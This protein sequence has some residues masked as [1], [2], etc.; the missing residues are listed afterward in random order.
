ME[1]SIE[2]PNPLVSDVLLAQNGDM[3]AYER[4]IKHCQNLV[5]SI[6]LSIV[7]DI[8][9]SEEVAQ[10]VF[11]SVW[12]NLNQLKSP[13]S[14]LPWV[15]Q[16]TRYTAF[17]FLRDNKVSSKVGSIHA[18]L[19]LEQLTGPE[20]QNEEQLYIDNQQLVLRHFIDELAQEEREIVLLYYR[21][22]QSSKQ[23]ARLLNLTEAN[24]R[25]KLSRVR[26]SLKSSLLKNASA[27]I[28][29]TAPAL[30]FSALIT[31]VLVPSSPVA[32]AAIASTIGTSS[33]ASTGF[34]VKFFTVIGGS[35]LGAFL[36]VFAIMWSSN[37]AM[38]TLGQAEHKKRLKRYRNETIV[39]VIAWGFIIT[40]GYEFTSTWVGPVLTY[41]VFAIG[42][43][44]LMVRSMNLLH[45]HSLN[46]L[47]E[48]ASK[49]RI[50]LNY[51]CMSAAVILGFTGL[52][53]GLISSGRL[54]I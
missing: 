51:L 34:L 35:L 47:G 27:Y 52:V 25:K 22:E 46:T 10:Q 3:Q 20:L 31:G 8:D 26:Q 41:T 44:L 54:V 18:N 33:K 17:N 40:A 9:D 5:S 11:V 37:Q 32:A 42:L 48:K 36:A 43:V 1:H 15:R 49:G 7:K 19:I 12:Q 14:F 53:V 50:A 13:S 39:W 16:S 6:A 29:N 45:M 23:V 2:R 38:K 21:E 30:G 24:V 4:L 28:Y